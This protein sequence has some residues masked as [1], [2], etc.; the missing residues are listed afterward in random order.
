[1][2][3]NLFSHFPNILFNIWPESEYW[4]YPIGPEQSETDITS[5]CL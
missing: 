1:M 3:L 5:L 2:N 4:L